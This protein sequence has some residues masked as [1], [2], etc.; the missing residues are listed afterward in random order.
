MPKKN[1]KLQ[2]NDTIQNNKQI[3]KVDANDKNSSSIS[4]ANNTLKDNKK[5]KL[6]KEKQLR[7]NALKIKQY[8]DILENDKELQLKQRQ[9]TKKVKKGIRNAILLMISIVGLP[10]GVFKLIKNL[11]KKQAIKSP[12]ELKKIII[13]E[14]ALKKHKEKNKRILEAY[15]EEKERIKRLKKLPFKILNHINFLISMLLIILFFFVLDIGVAPTLLILFTS[16]CFCYFLIGVLMHL[17]FYMIAENK[18]RE[19]MTKLE[20]EKNRLLAEEKLKAD[21]ILRNKIDTERKRFEEI[22][23]LRIQEEKR[24]AIEAEELRLIKE[25]EA[26]IKAE[27]RQKI[28]ELEAEKERAQQIRRNKFLQKAIELPPSPTIA[29]LAQEKEALRNEFNRNLLNEIE[30]NFTIPDISGIEYFT[31]KDRLQKEYGGNILFKDLD[32]SD[33]T[34]HQEID[35]TMLQAV[36]EVNTKNDDITDFDTADIEE[37]KELIFRKARM[38]VEEEKETKGKAVSGKSFMILKQMLKDE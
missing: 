27:E 37:A 11:K 25:E 29:E 28:Q 32:N 26:R 36:K 30:D 17:V 2:E 3:I 19:E 31:D 9:E 12:F 14:E 34:L 1:K 5:T 23:R 24:R 6:S 4:I 15:K 38:K 13:T 35:N 10:F 8:E 16:F 18:T 7:K 20:E 22:E 21:A 33:E